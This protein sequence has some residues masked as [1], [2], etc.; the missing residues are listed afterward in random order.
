MS[1]FTILRCKQ[2]VTL[3]KYLLEKC[4]RQY[5]MCNA[6]LYSTGINNNHHKNDTAKKERIARRRALRLQIVQD[7]KQTKRKVEEIIEKENIWTIPNFLCMGRIVTSPYLSYLILSQDYQVA[8]WLLIIAGFSDL[9]DGWIAR[10]WTS[11]ASKLGSFLDPVADKLL[12]GTL[13][14]S[15]AWVGL[16]PIPLACLV[17]ARDVA[18]VSAAS[19]I[20][21]QSL[22]PPKTLARYFDAT[23]AT[24]QLAPTYISK[25]NTVVQLSFVTGTLA[26]PIFHFVNH[27]ILEGLCYVTALTTLAGGISYLISKNTYKFL[28]KK[29]P[30][31]SSR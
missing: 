22:P 31:K 9:A 24:V 4:L 6:S 8:L 1:Y 11:Q 3:N 5:L 13:F 29:T 7:I 30:T 27:P 26:A 28:R 25:I 10:T 17:I 20:R 15:L 2:S 23:H 16:V 12:V 21:Y 14:L 19:Y 18:L